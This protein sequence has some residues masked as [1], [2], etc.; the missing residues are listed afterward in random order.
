MRLAQERAH[1]KKYQAM[2]DAHASVR[3]SIAICFANLDR[4]Q[5]TEIMAKPQCMKNTCRAEQSE[6]L[7]GRFLSLHAHSKDGAT[8][9]Q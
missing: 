8:Q 2:P 7:L 6:Y 1:P 5:P 4:T 9:S 3:I